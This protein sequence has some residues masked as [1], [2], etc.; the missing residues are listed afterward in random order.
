MFNPTGMDLPVA[1]SVVDGR[2]LE[3]CSVEG[4]HDPLVVP[5]DATVWLA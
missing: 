3:L 5:A 1:P 2:H 4:Y